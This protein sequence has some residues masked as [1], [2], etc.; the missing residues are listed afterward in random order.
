MN[1]PVTERPSVYV[2]NSNRW[3]HDQLVKPATA[4][5]DSFAWASSPEDADMLIYPVPEW[6]D[7]EAPHSLRRLS[8]RTWWPRIFLY[9]T[10]DVPLAWA[11]GVFASIPRRYASRGGFRG[12]CYVIHHHRESGGMAELIDRRLDEP[13]PQD[14]LWSFV[15]TVENDPGVRGRVMRLDD[16]R[17]YVRDTQQWKREIR[18][19]WGGTMKKEGEEAF[20]SYVD[21][22]GRSKFIVCPRG[23][24]ASSMRLFEAM[25]MRRCPV[26]VSDDWTP[27]PFV[28]WDACAVMVP[29]ADIDRL[30]AILRAREHEAEALGRNAQAAWERYFSPSMT[31][32]A[33]VEACIDIRRNDGIGSRERLEI[34]TRAVPT[35]PFAE[36]ALTRARGLRARVRR[37]QASA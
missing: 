25:Q 10:N 3:L 36:R 24:G 21:I 9:S 16:E 32:P 19:N 6:A 33:I 18:W 5:P 14:L 1:R 13:L 35:R 30:P 7:P 28:D 23:V 11:P 20:A 37:S 17:A 4:S 27:P 15:G 26:I 8:I 31:L 34:A 12:G 22:A 29:E 2:L